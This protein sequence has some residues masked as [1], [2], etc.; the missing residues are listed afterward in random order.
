MLENSINGAN[1]LGDLMLNNVLRFVY[2]R[3]V[4][5][6]F[7]GHQFLCSFFEFISLDAVFRLDSVFIFAL[8]ARLHGLSTEYILNLDWL[9]YWFLSEAS[10]EEFLSDDDLSANPS[11]ILMKIDYI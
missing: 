8:C 7:M 2:E 6:S 5:F 9:F 4:I 11:L 1:D 3:F 10:C